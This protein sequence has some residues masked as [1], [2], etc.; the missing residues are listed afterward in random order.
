MEPLM[1]RRMINIELIE[2]ITRMEEGQK[3]L[4]SLLEAHLV[5]SCATNGCELH[6]EV[7]SLSQNF[8]LIKVVAY[9]CTLATIGLITKAVWRF[10]PWL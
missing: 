7:K 6:D 8:R 9:S 10:V 1:E 2:R 5:A 3:H 4:I